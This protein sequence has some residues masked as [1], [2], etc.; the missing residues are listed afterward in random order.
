MNSN[1]SFEIDYK[2]INII[3]SKIIFNNNNRLSIEIGCGQDTFILKMAKRFPGENF[4][5][6]EIDGWVLKRLLKKVMHIN[7]DNVR[8]IRGDAKRIIERYVLDFSIANFFINQ[9]DPWPKKRHRQRRLIKDEFLDILI[10]KL[11]KGG[12]IYYTSDFKDYA[13]QVAGK[14]YST[15]KMKPL[16]NPF[17]IIDLG[18]YPKTRFMKRF[19]REGQP[20]FFT[21]FEKIY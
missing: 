4:I 19:L 13:Y 5:G 9:P 6:I 16:F 20:I 17:V 14:L 1:N 10:N 21:I 12:R 3:S 7:P 18:D 11:H 8:F 2:E 15:K